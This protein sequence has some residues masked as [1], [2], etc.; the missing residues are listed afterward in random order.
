MPDKPLKLLLVIEE[1]GVLLGQPEAVQA[2]D[3]ADPKGHLRDQ[4]NKA[5]AT[6]RAAGI[7]TVFSTQL[8]STLPSNTLKLLNTLIAFK[9]D[10][11]D[12]RTVLAKQMNMLPG[13]AESLI[14]CRPGSA[15]VKVPG[16]RHPQ[17]VQFDLSHLMPAGQVRNDTLKKKLAQQP[18]FKR[19]ERRRVALE[20]D[21]LGSELVEAQAVLCEHLRGLQHLSERLPNITRRRGA[22]VAAQTLRLSSERLQRWFNRFEMEIYEPLIGEQSTVAYRAPE[23]RAN[24]RL[25]EQLMSELRRRVDSAVNRLRNAEQRYASEKAWED[26]DVAT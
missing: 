18:W 25:L 19:N 5:A 16:R 2:G 9:T 22:H 11:D 10:H 23:L 20:L 26:A 13:Q 12:E 8:T 4:V 3:R 1:A 15:F 7:G 14:A 17:F 24:R 21:Q 6:L